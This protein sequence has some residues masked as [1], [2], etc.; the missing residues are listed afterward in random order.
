MQ[1]VSYVLNRYNNTS[2]QFLNASPVID[3]PFSSMHLKDL[4]AYFKNEVEI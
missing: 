1:N 4:V 3:L 2:M